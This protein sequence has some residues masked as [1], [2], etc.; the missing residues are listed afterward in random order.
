MC[1]WLLWRYASSKLP[2]VLL[3]N[4]AT[5]VIDT[6]ALQ[7]FFAPQ[8]HLQSIVKDCSRRLTK[9]SYF[10]SWMT[11]RD[12][13][14]SAF[15][16]SD[17]VYDMKI[18]HDAIVCGLRNGTVE[19]WNRKTLKKEFSLE[20]QN[21][22]VQVHTVLENHRKSLI[23][24]HCERSELRLHFRVARIL[25]GQTV[26]PDRFILIGQKLVKNAKKLKS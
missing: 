11:R 17:D 7:S 15:Q 1:L 6:R 22:S 8:F 25:K 10:S 19:I 18:L 16:C 5:S 4:C 21:G 20:D 12:V 24:Q 2:D 3:K 9:S 23:S 13:E 26:L 14:E